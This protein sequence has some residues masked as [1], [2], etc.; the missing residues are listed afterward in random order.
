MN[1]AP[2]ETVGP[3]LTAKVHALRGRL[4]QLGPRVLA[5]AQDEDAVHDLRVA[6]R[7]TRTALEVGRSVFGRFYSDEVRGAL[8]GVQR[9]TGALRDE[10]VLLELVSSLHV[11][12]ASVPHWLE[13]RRDRERRLRRQLVGLIET[14]QLDR[15]LDL[16]DA[17]LAFRVNPSRDRRLAKFARRA[18]AGARRQVDRRRA[19]RIDD[20]LTLHQLRIAYKRLRYVVEMFADALPSDLTALAQSASRMQNRLGAVHDV[21]VAL[22]CVRRARALTDEARR[23]VLAEMERMR[24]ERIAA[25]AIETAPLA[26]TTGPFAHVSGG[27]GLRKTSTR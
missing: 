16:L 18:V 19:S 2:S 8:R 11:T 5:S 13:C 12:H 6:L 10:E 26:Y 14:G 22:G 4:R 27:E 20:P 25:Y 21:D 3:H 23:E 9:A 15:G 7:R 17:L 24:A 1:G